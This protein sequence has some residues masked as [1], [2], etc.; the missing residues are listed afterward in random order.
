MALFVVQY[1]SEYSAEWRIGAPVA[2]SAEI[3]LGDDF[4]HEQNEKFVL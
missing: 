2:K 4:G 3:A 1:L